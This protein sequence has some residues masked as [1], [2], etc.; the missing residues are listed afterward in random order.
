MVHSLSRFDKVLR[1]CLHLFAPGGKLVSTKSQWRI[2]AYC[3]IT[4]EAQIIMIRE[5]HVRGPSLHSWQEIL[6]FKGLPYGINFDLGWEDE[7]SPGNYPARTLWLSLIEH[8]TFNP[9]PVRDRTILVYITSYPLAPW[10]WQKKV[11]NPNS[12]VDMLSQ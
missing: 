3:S 4:M 7:S 1:M 5:H 9:C 6:G 11:T 2:V 12:L 8:M 10:T